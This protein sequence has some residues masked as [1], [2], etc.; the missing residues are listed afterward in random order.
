MKQ[1]WAGFSPFVKRTAL[2][3]LSAVLLVRDLFHPVNDLPVER[4]LNGDMCHRDSRAGTMP[5]LLI[6]FEPNHVA[7]PDFFNRAA[8]PLHSANAGCDDQRL[9]ERMGVP[10]R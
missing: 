8:Q 10:C 9:A 3:S 4:F 2:S 6:R 5:V 7:R 1:S